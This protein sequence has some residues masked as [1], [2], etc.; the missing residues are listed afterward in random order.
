MFDRKI[1]SPKGKKAIGHL[2][3]MQP[4]DRVTLEGSRGVPGKYSARN[5]MFDMRR[6][7]E[8]LSVPRNFFF[9]VV[10][11]KRCI[12]YGSDEGNATF[13]CWATAKAKKV[14]C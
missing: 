11:V 5:V 1:T 13:W 3:H 12:L 10:G 2:E 9:L 7:H 4:T 8:M 14:L 6:G